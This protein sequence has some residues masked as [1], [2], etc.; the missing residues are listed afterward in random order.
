MHPLGDSGAGDSTSGAADGNDGGL[1]GG[2]AGGA[3][4]GIAAGD[5]LLAGAV[6]SQSPAP[7]AAAQARLVAWLPHRTQHQ[8]APAVWMGLGLPPPEL[9]LRQP[10]RRT[11]AISKSKCR[12][13]V[14]RNRATE[15]ER[16]AFGATE[17]RK[18]A[19]VQPVYD[20]P[21]PL[22]RNAGIGR[23]YNQPCYCTD[24]ARRHRTSNVTL[25]A[26]RQRF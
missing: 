22:D 7:A 18:T 1:G 13:V 26:L 8:L 19:P 6:V 11:S 17:G 14:R 24:V 3:I 15:S 21:T 23:L 20:E 10:W 5:L 9:E 2:H 12:L 25:L 16:R 4:A